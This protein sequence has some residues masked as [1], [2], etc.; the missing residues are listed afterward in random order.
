VAHR[1]ADRVAVREATRFLGVCTVEGRYDTAP[2]FV[3]PALMT[4]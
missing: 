2:S 1:E 3:G 4:E